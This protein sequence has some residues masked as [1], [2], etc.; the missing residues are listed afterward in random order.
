M[1]LW[2]KGLGKLVLKLRLSE[3]GA[4][5]DADE[6]LVV[7]GR[8]GAPTHWD[9]AIKLGEDDVLEFL[10]LLKQPT[11][12]KFLVGART[13][14]RLVRTALISG[15]IFLLDTLGLFLRPGDGS[16]D[17][18]GDRISKVTHNEE[19]TRNE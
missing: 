11:P 13:S 12:T 9:Y 6:R 4:M 5:R 3:R 7:D 15:F 18:S 14:G 10:E 16:R 17:V 1:I 19:S 8:L 2:S